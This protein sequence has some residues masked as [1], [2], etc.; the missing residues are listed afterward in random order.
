LKTAQDIY[1]EL[2]A[3]LGDVLPDAELYIKA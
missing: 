2:Q 3:K 1:R